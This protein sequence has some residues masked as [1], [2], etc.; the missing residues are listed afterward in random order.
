MPNRSYLKA[1][2]VCILV[3]LCL[4]SQLNVHAQSFTPTSFVTLG[5][6]PGGYPTCA[7]AADF[8][9]D[10]KIDMVGVGSFSP[11]LMVFANKWS[12]DTVAFGPETN[13]TTTGT[14]HHAVAAGD[15][16]GD[17]K[18]D[19][20]LVN[21]NPAS[22][23]VY[24]NTSSG[25]AITFSTNQ[26]YPS[27]NYPYAIAIGDVDGD[28]KPDIVIADYSGGVVS[29]YR[30][31]GTPGNISFAARVDIPAGSGPS[32]VA[33]GDVDGDGKPDLAITT[34]GTN[35][36]LSVMSN[37][38]TPGTVVFASPV[39]YDPT[40][41]LSAAAIADLDGDG[42]PDLAAVNPSSNYLAVVE[43]GS[44]PG[45]FI[46]GAPQH[47]PS[48]ENPF[49]LS[50]G[51]LDGDGKPDLVSAG[52]NPSQ[53]LSAFKNTSTPGSISF[54][55]HSDYPLGEPAIYFTALADLDG[56]GRP[57]VITANSGYNSF[58]FLG[59]MIGVVVPVINSF[60]PGE[61]V[62]GTVVT[63]KGSGFTGATGV[64]FGGV[65]ASSFTVVS[66]TVLTAVVG[67]GATGAVGI[68][69]ANVSIT[70]SDFLFYGPVISSFS[71]AVAS[72][73]DTVRISGNYFTD[74]TSVEFGNVPAAS[75]TVDSLT[76]ITAIVG[77]GIT[78]DVTVSSPNGTSTQPGFTYAPP[79][80]TGI[81]PLAGSVGSVVTISG[82]NFNADTVTNFVYFGAVRA[83][84]ITAS[85]T[86]L[87]VRA[88]AGATYQPTSV[89]A[90]YLS[91]YSSASFVYTFPSDSPAI[92]AN[93]FQ[94][95]GNYTTGAYPV[96][97]A[98][99]DL[100][101]D[102]RPDLITLDEAS[103]NFSIFLNRST[104]GHVSFLPKVDI[105]TYGAGSRRIAVADFNGDGKPDIAV[106]N[107][108][109]G[110]GATVSYFFNQ[111]Y[112]ETIAFDGP[113]PVAASNGAQGLCIADMNG[114][115]RP[116]ILTA[117]G[118]SGTYSIFPN[119]T[120][121]S[122]FVT[123]G[124]RMDFANPNNAGYI[125]TADLDGDGR[126]DIITVSASTQT[127]SVY[128]NTG[129][130][131]QYAFGTRMGFPTGA[132][133]AYV[134]AGDLDG[135]GKPD[136]IVGDASGN[137]L[138]FFKN[139]STP[140]NISLDTRVDSALATSSAAAADFNGDGKVDIGFS[141]NPSGAISVLPNSYPGTGPLAFAPSV[142][143]VPGNSSTLLFSGDLDGDSKPDLAVLNP[144]L[145]SVG[146]WRNTI[147]D[148][149]ITGMSTDT[150]YL[151]TLITLT[152]R[153]FTGTVAVN[154]GGVA[155]D[156][157]HVVSPTRIDAVVGPGASGYVTATTL[158]GIDSI[159][160]FIFIPQITASGKTTFCL[161]G[162]VILTSTAASNNQ[163]YRNGV[164]LA[165][166]TTTTFYA[167]S[168]GTYTVQT[169]SNGITTSSTGLVV[170]V[171]IIPAPV[172]TEEANGELVSGAVSGNQWYFDYAEQTG[173]TNQIYKP[174]QSGVY[175]V[176]ST[177]NGC[178]S[179][180][181][182]PY[183]VVLSGAINLGNDQS[184]A[185]WPNPVTNQLY[186]SQHVNGQPLT[187]NISITDVRGNVLQ[188]IQNVNQTVVNMALY[189]PG[190]Y[191][192]T[193]AGEGSI[194]FKKTV[195]I[196]KVR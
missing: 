53:L 87:T 14:A 21:T 47:I 8:N 45:N 58:I 181:S 20:V 157:F 90:G 137:I 164:A 4:L 6:L 88:P 91:G 81:S 9:G 124:Q 71:P 2:L 123:F 101:G 113:Q 66:D 11:A 24:R 129:A 185:Y 18:P 172:I 63:F 28:G 105:S 173:D 3:C 130:G 99:S 89:S 97:M 23:S 60:F 127:L 42:K 69:N 96:D 169:T 92:T 27:N 168:S 184:V 83:P 31:T 151:G 30:N 121:N 35:G 10:G 194:T 154:F 135:D 108:N 61:G 122:T 76:G 143:V 171:I 103:D 64:T 182:A 67:P 174:E 125:I 13:L 112:G 16:D 98:M 140:G 120:I 180:M 79:V 107:T 94:P 106:L 117:N 152:G 86:Q 5:E 158:Y 15:L 133:P 32:S 95:A 153:N 159:A 150:G 73:G 78:G 163:W 148:P 179:L 57:D 139:L 141:G 46:F 146:V 48:L 84:V 128:P 68:S 144:A 85:P 82:R 44:S 110:N 195:K 183:Y 186:V 134:K 165:D 72:A 74:I 1:H 36:G 102:G 100:D 162:S 70:R 131:G 116:D 22:I 29:V 191:Y 50:I 188:T 65:A 104:I 54:D 26:D 177:Q 126:P 12:G 52:N 187:L 193:V 147:G 62:T 178:T 56:N 80:I 175:Q 149:V 170:T 41:G 160:G 156:S 138:S 114:D 142:G 192:L 49:T 55:A 43:N 51:D 33:I 115:G 166:D 17:G 19:L 59:N 77:K 111:F 155:A 145:N 132:N 190:V 176:T 119:S 118:D 25:A 189:P 7:T 136:L 38:S 109:N 39:V 37:A 167:D 93:S 161:G 196:L 75:F 34:Q 40:P